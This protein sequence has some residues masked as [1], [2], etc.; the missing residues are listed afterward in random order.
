MLEKDLFWKERKFAKEN[1]SPWPWWELSPGAR[2]IYEMLKAQYNGPDKGTKKTNNGK[3]TLFRDEVLA[4]K[5]NGL[6][7]PNTI[8]AALKELIKEGWIK[9]EKRIG[10]KHRW[11]VFYRLTWKFDSLQ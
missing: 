7:S 10:G 2:A 4:M 3:L 11:I 9:E 8:T 5:I 1:P 6:S